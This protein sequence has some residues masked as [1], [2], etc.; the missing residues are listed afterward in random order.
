M[1]SLIT[2]ETVYDHWNGNPY[3]GSVIQ[4]HWLLQITVC[5]INDTAEDGND[6]SNVEVYTTI[7]ILLF[8]KI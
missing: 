8:A 2:M 4:I 1:K 3:C 7:Y 5:Q 6:E